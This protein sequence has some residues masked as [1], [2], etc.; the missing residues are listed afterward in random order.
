MKGNDAVLYY[1]INRLNIYIVDDGLNRI[2][3]QV[4]NDSYVWKILPGVS[5]HGNISLALVLT[6]SN[7]A[8]SRDAVQLF[9]SESL[10]LILAFYTVHARITVPRLQETLVVFHIPASQGS[11]LAYYDINFRLFILFKHIICIQC[12]EL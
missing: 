5:G 12:S 10:S 11:P 2:V 9:Y 1:T 4:N 6:C 7:F 8:N 3:R